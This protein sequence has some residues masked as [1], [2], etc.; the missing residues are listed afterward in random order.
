MIAIVLPAFNEEESIPS[1]IE[2]I[3]RISRKRLPEGVIIIVVDDGSTDNTA[4]CVQA[5]AR[6]DI[7]LLQHP[8]NMGLGE[9]IRTGLLHSI[10]LSPEVDVIKQPS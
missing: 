4:T 6:S 7:V 3:R 1:L 10:S 8:N 9:A 2:N 5:L